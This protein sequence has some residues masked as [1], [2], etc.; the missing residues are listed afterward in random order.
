MP[1]SWLK[2]QTAWNFLARD[3]SSPYIDNRPLATPGTAEV[4]ETMAYGGLNDQQIGLQSDIVS[5]TFGG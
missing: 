3:T 2:G 1:T 5:V 4:R